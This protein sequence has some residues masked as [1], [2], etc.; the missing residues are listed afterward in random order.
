MRLAI[1]LAA[2]VCLGLTAT[3]DGMSRKAVS[4]PDM[5]RLTA[6]EASIAPAS[7]GHEP[8][9][10][11]HGA[12]YSVLPGDTA[13][14]CEAACG[15]DNACRAWSFVAAYGSA[16]ARCE[17]KRGGGKSE[18]NLLATSGVSPNVDVSYWGDVPAEAPVS[19]VVLEGDAPEIDGN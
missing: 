12:T 10:Y 9:R 7:A 8:F 13:L 18:E 5:D 11:L 1:L 4:S 2:T 15:D 17:L 6:T 3:A 19:S 16:E 14:A